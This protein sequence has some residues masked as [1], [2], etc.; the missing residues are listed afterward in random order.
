MKKYVKP[1]L[2][3]ESFEMSQQIA[4]CTFDSKGNQND[5]MTCGFTGVNPTTGKLE[6]LFLE[7]TEACASDAEYYCYHGS[8][9]GFSIF[10][11]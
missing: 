3:F 4:E 1:E 10:N 11:S 6:T 5:V 9:G 8:S 2:A 7:A